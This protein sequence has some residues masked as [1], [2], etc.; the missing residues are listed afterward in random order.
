MIQIRAG[1]LSIYGEAVQSARSGSAGF[2]LFHGHEKAREGTKRKDFEQ[3][4]T[5]G[6][7]LECRMMSDE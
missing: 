7:E 2:L 5:E 3:E 4:A 6:T 1:V